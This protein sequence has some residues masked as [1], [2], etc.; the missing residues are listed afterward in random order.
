MNPFEPNEVEIFALI[1]DNMGSAT[2]V[3][4]DWTQFEEAVFDCEETQRQRQ[5]SR[6]I[7][8]AKRGD[9]DDAYAEGNS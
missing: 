8:K 1:E 5:I 6:E 4:L 2:H 7:A 3:P 9:Y